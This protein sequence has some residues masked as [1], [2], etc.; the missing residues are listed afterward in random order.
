MQ[1]ALCDDDLALLEEMSA[2]VGAFLESKCLD[3][4]LSCFTES[5]ALLASETAFDLVFL[6]IGLAGSNGLETAR[7]LRK[8]GYE[9]LLIFMTVLAEWVYDAFEV[10]AFAYLLKPIEEERLQRTLERAVWQL[11]QAAKGQ[12]AV[13]KGHSCR[14]IPLSELIYCEVI[15]RKIYLHQQN[16]ETIDYYERL[17][18]LAK[19]LDERF[20]RCHR[21]YLVNLDWVRGLENERVLLADG[22]DIPVSRL[23]EQALLAS[24]LA[25]MKARRQCGG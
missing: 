15:G 10:Q 11:T 21:S 22:S 9:G 25:R 18:E 2:R 6:D 20:F 23:R 1:V 5:A 4:A 16:G 24:L 14:L 19:R 8:R 3:F 17:E 13:V 12:L 7:M